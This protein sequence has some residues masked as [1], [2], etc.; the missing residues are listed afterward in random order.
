MVTGLQ[1]LSQRSYLINR[2]TAWR[3]VLSRQTGCGSDNE[4]RSHQ[5]HAGKK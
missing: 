1:S 4:T 2:D 5:G 3:L